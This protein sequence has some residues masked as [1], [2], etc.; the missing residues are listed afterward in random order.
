MLEE[1]SVA[2]RPSE[3]TTQMSRRELAQNVFWLVVVLAVVYGFARL[4]GF[5]RIEER[6]EALGIFGP[7]LL[8]LLKASTLVFAPLGGAP[9]YPIAGA[10]FGFSK[11]LA[12]MTVGDVVGSSVAF[13]ISR[14]FGTRI[15]TYF[16]S[17]PGMRAAEE[18]L[19]YIGTTKGIVQ[20]RI[21]FAGFP[22]AVHYAAGL[23]M[24]AYPRYM[25]IN[26]AI[27]LVPTAVLV[28][29]G[30]ILV[31]RTSAGALIAASIVASALGLGGAWW[32]VRQARATHS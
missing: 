10:L 28:A 5:D 12:I 27:G 2:A 30:R 25:L 14:R 11:G 21:F 18:V 32:L 7:L 9:L 8:A 29:L 16:L 6:V 3:A 20:A 24:I 4:I 15:A 23:T 22:E 17:K 26:I 1:N 19:R 13:W 31:E